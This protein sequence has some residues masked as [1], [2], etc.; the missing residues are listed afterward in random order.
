MYTRKTLAAAAMSHRWGQARAATIATAAA[1]HVAATRQTST[2]E[3][4]ASTATAARTQTRCTRACTTRCTAWRDASTAQPG[5]HLTLKNTRQTLAKTMQEHR[6]R[7]DAVATPAPE[8]CKALATTIHAQTTARW[9]CGARCAAKEH[10]NCSCRCASTH[11]PHTTKH[12][13]T[14]EQTRK[15]ASKL[16]ITYRWCAV[17]IVV[18]PRAASDTLSPPSAFISSRSACI[19]ARS[20]HCRESETREE[21]SEC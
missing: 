12:A 11:T 2:R 3:W 6:R 4:R 10:A 1:S 9:R 21:R 18:M 16:S 20:I 5:R 14:S 19:S 15:H 8:C 7:V 17:G 13:R